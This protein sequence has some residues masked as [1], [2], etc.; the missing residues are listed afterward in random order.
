MHFWYKLHWVQ[1]A[2]PHLVFFSSITSPKPITFHIPT[3]QPD[4]K[5]HIQPGIW[6]SHDVVYIHETVSLCNTN[7]CKGNQT[8]NLI[9]TISKKKG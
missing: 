9:S 3:D 7:V 4:L 8:I 2:N 1:W 6:N 5:A